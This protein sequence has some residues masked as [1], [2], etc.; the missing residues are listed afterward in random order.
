MSIL[1]SLEKAV[2]PSRSHISVCVKLSFEITKMY[3]KWSQWSPGNFYFGSLN[4][5]IENQTNLHIRQTDTEAETIW[6]ERDFKIKL[7]NKIQQSTLSILMVIAFVALHFLHCRRN[8]F[9][10]FHHTPMLKSVSTCNFEENILHCLCFL[11]WHYN[12]MLLRAIIYNLKCT[13]QSFD[14][15]HSK[16]IQM[17]TNKK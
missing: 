17:I 16:I 3:Q 8:K 10:H 15:R 9:R 13:P 14:S 6:V 5:Q 12:A 2:T 1:F 11:L 4:R 7:A